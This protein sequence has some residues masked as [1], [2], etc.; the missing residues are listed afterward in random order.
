MKAV[1]KPLRTVNDLSLVPIG[2]ACSD[3]RHSRGSGGFLQECGAEARSCRAV[4]IDLDGQPCPHWA[5]HSGWK[6]V[7]ELIARVWDPET[8]FGIFMGITLFVLLGALVYVAAARGC[9]DAVLDLDS[10]NGGSMRKCP[11]EGQHIEQRGDRVLCVCPTT[12]EH[13]GS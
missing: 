1:G 6:P 13:E 9:S 8:V 3:C 5:A 12:P 2:N 10:W 7:L 11:Y 4:R